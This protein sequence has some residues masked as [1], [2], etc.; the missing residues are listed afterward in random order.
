MDD[1]RRSCRKETGAVC[2]AARRTLA[3][4]APP[5]EESGKLPVLRP[6]KRG[7]LGC[8][9]EVRTQLRA[10]MSVHPSIPAA[11]IERPFRLLNEFSPL[12][13]PRLPSPSIPSC[14]LTSRAKRQGGKQK[15]KNLEP[16][17]DGL[18]RA[19]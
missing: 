14:R 13:H 8:V 18:P 11:E 10:A 9:R 16:I 6:S 5:I 3:G 4:P 2:H 12:S 19:A 1:A 17:S 15:A 7:R